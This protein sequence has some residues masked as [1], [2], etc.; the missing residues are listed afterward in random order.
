MVL[1]VSWDTCSGST[2]NLEQIHVY[3]SK[4]YIINSKTL[5]IYLPYG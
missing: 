5:V 3:Q 4:T 2:L 1:A